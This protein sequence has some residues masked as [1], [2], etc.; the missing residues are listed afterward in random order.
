MFYDSEKHIQDGIV[1]VRFFQDEKATPPTTH[2]HQFDW[3]ILSKGFGTPVGQEID[4]IWTFDKSNYSTTA[5][6][7]NLYSN[8]TD[9]NL[10]EDNVEAYIFDDDNTDNLQKI[11]RAHV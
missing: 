8:D 10:T 7:N 3:V 4:P 9:T 2:I 6:A 11:G 1:Q 5:Q